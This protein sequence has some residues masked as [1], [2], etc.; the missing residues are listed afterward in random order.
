MKSKYN[1]S[2]KEKQSLCAKRRNQLIKNA[3][4]SELLFKD[5]LDN[6]NI[7]YLF[8]KGFTAGKG[9]YIVDFY[10]PSP[11]KICIEIDGGYHNTPIQIFKD[12]NRTKY[13]EESRGFKVI[14]FTN[15]EV[16]KLTLEQIKERISL[17][18]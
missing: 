14:R 11:Y 5:I 4:K 10:L 13:L 15:D 12:K 8:Q 3:T 7:R 6:L 18:A 17:L 2:K 1:L 9:F 16:T